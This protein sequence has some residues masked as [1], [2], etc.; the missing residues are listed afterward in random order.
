MIIFASDYL[1]I[2][3]LDMQFK[4]VC[5]SFLVAAAMSVAFNVNT[6]FADGD[7]RAKPMP[8]KK[9]AVVAPA[10]VAAPVA[11]V[12]MKQEVV[13][14]SCG[15]GNMRLSGGVPVWFLDNEDTEAAPGVALD[16][17]CSEIPLNYRVAVEGRHLDLDQ[18][19]AD[20]ARESADKKAKISYVRIPF[21][22]EYMAELD[23]STTGYIGG[24]PDIINA[25]NDISDT[26]VGGHLS[27]RVHYA[28]TDEFGFSLEAGY[29]WA[30]FDGEGS[31]VNLDGAYVTP[32]LTYT[33]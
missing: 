29:M 6:S 25:A 8:K 28:F 27:A 19:E 7:D 31:D 32:M 22:V 12:A 30:R 5:S 11:P 2:L 17:W 26:T 14:E 15:C 3:G 16:Y 23:E 18:S 20:F 9:A 4:S 21:S 24:G 33:F 13:D 1:L 10:P